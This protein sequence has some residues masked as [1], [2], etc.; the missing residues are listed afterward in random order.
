MIIMNWIPIGLNWT[1]LFNMGGMSDNLIWVTITSRKLWLSGENITRR[2][3]SCR[4][5]LQC[6]KYSMPLLCTVQNTSIH[7]RQAATAS[8]GTRNNKGTCSGQD[9]CL[10]RNKYTILQTTIPLSLPGSCSRTAYLA[11]QDGYSLI[12]DTALGTLLTQ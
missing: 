4:Q 9:P 7:Q 8:S 11:W 1:I 2:C 12:R 5:T 3:H 10:V 6:Q